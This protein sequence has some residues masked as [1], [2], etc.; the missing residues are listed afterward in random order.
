MYTLEVVAIENGRFRVSSTE[1]NP[2]PD[3][4]VFVYGREVN[5]FH[6][7]DYEA[8]S[9]LNISAT[10][11]LAKRL[12]NSENSLT[13]VEDRLSEAEARNQQLEATLQTVLDRL[14]ELEANEQA[15]K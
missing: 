14:G 12:L 4:E 2:L 9:T 1:A 8:L 7:V 3:G 11:E 15:T 10:Q 13:K 6:T 5:N